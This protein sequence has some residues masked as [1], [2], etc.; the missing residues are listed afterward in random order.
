MRKSVLAL[1]LVSILGGLT[2]KAACLDEYR[3]R[4]FMPSETS[5]TMAAI[6]STTG[7]VV[8]VGGLELASATSALG[9]QVMADEDGGVLADLVG[10]DLLSDA[11]SSAT[12]AVYYG[13]SSSLAATGILEDGDNF[14]RE[15]ELLEEAQLYPSVT[16]SAILELTDDIN[17]IRTA[18]Q[19]KVDADDVAR[20]VRAGDEREAF[21]RGGDMFDLVDIR[22]YVSSRLK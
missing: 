21:C 13:T 8:F 16:G 12:D 17:D 19:G 14:N 11:S 1:C 4:N 6:S 9:V 20:I 22:D 2:T 5:K 15:I 3:D 7:T 10:M 18:N